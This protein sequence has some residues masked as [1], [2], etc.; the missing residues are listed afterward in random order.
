MVRTIILALG[1]MLSVAAQAQE[2]K[3][4]D[5]EAL[6]E[7]SNMDAMIES[8]YAQTNKMF[9]GMGQQLGIKPDEQ[10]MFDDY[11]NEVT[12][13]MR[14]EVSWA[15]MKEP[16]VQ[17]YLK[18]Y[19][20]KEI[21]DMLAFYQSATGQSMVKKM[22]AVTQDSMMLSQQMLQN[23]LP[24]IQVIAEDFNQKLQAHRQAK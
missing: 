4:A 24:K 20:D 14:K 1:L 13:A 6:L 15:K 21:K 3:R 5:V 11:M 16:M 2:A 19:S 22:P 23:F 10:Q 7:A 18:H 8:I 9:A 17:I 12:S